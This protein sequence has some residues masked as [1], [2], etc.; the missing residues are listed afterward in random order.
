MVCWNSIVDSQILHTNL[1]VRT[2]AVAQQTRL[3]AKLETQMRNSV[4]VPCCS[5]C[6]SA[7]CVMASGLGPIPL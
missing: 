6:N 1:D 4:G 2:S 3:L 5:A 7:S